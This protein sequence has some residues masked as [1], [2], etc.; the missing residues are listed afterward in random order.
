MLVGALGALPSASIGQG[1]FGMYE[2]ISASAPDIAG[3]N[4][5]NPIGAILSAAML[6]EHTY[7]DSRGAQSITDATEAVLDMGFAPA[8]VAARDR[9]TVTGTSEFGEL[10]CEA[11]SRCGIV[12]MR[13]DRVA[14]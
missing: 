14:Q 13:T 8:D 1:T 12:R 3:K 2:P 4:Q 10:V 5:A 6:L 7:G 9:T 11:L